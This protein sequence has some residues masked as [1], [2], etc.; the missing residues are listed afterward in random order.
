MAVPIKLAAATW[1]IEDVCPSYSPPNLSTRASFAYLSP[2]LTP[3]FQSP[4]LA[5]YY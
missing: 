2:I 3:A 5:E 4:L 1:R